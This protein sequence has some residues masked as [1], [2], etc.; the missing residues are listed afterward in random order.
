MLGFWVFTVVMEV[1]RE[2]ERER[3]IFYCIEILFYAY[4]VS[5]FLSLSL[6]QSSSL[7]HSV[8]TLS[9]ISHFS[10]SFKACTGARLGSWFDLG[11]VVGWDRLMVGLDRHGSAG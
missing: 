1:K 5:H 11:M 4:N 9:L 3:N 7:F 10:F 6:S 2:R 8:L